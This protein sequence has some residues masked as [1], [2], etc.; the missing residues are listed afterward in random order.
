MGRPIA[1]P[2]GRPMGIHTT[3]V[4]ESSL[5]GSML[6]KSAVKEW[7]SAK[8]QSAAFE[9]KLRAHKFAY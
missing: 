6:T 9:P 4:L 7:T 8:L 3:L 2:M 5:V 1:L